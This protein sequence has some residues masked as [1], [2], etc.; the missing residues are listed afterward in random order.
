MDICFPAVCIHQEESAEC[1]NDL[2]RP[3]PK[4]TF[5]CLDLKKLS[6]EEKEKLHQR[7][8]AE[9]MDITFKFQH[10]FSSTIL[11]LKERN[12]SPQDLYSHLVCLG[13]VKPA[14]HDPKQPILRQYF[15]QLRT[16]ERIEE[17]M[18]IIGDYCSFFNFS[19]IEL[20]IDKLGTTKDKANLTK[21]KKDFSDYARRHVYECPS[22][23]GMVTDGNAEL[24]MTL[25][26][27]YDSYTVSSLQLF[28]RKLAEIL[29]LSSDAALK[30]CRI[31]LGSLK[32]T[33]QIP[34][35]VQEDI[36][37]LSIDQ[38]RALAGLGVVHL[39][40]GDYHFTNEVAT[41]LHLVS[42]FIYHRLGNFCL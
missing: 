23:L 20:I 9:S 18:G 41:Y 1:S 40:C 35:F 3:K 38:K 6:K 36:F 29:K 13:S 32:L 7:L 5:S 33:F 14:Y 31:E 10:L 11:S 22:E 27:T 4:F 42:I 37:P 17:A 30:L 28:V 12:T 26:E 24:F 2:P 19:I 8:Y 34:I 25:D 15:P 21:Y 39:S 16:A